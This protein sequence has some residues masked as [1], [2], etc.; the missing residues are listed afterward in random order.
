MAATPP[1]RSPPSPTSVMEVNATSLLV[2]FSPE[3]KEKALPKKRRPSLAKAALQLSTRELQHQTS[4]FSSTYWHILVGVAAFFDFCATVLAPYFPEDDGL[5][6]VTTK[7]LFFNRHHKEYVVTDDPLLHDVLQWLDTWYVQIGVVFSV[8]LFVDAI[9]KAA[10]K[11]DEKIDRLRLLEDERDPATGSAWRA[12]Y[13]TMAFQLLVLPV[14]FYVALWGTLRFRWSTSESS[15]VDDESEV[16]G[17]F[18]IRSTHSLLFA[19]LNYTFMVTNRLVGAGIRSQRKALS[20]R[21]ARRMARF[22]FRHPRLFRYRLRLSLQIIRWIKYLAPLVGGLNKLFGNTM[23]LLKKYRQRVMANRA[24][25]MRKQRWHE[26]SPLQKR[27]AAA[28]LIQKSFRG[29]ES[30]KA[31]RALN[32]LEGCKKTMIAIKMQQAF[33]ASLARARER[34]A[35]KKRELKRL[36]AQAA[37]AKKHEMSDD[38]RRLMYQLQDELGMRAKELVNK[39]LLLRPNTTFAVTWKFLFVMCVLYEISMNCL[40]HKLQKYKDEETGKPLDFGRILEHKFVPSPISEWE[41]CAPWFAGVAEE[42][43][44]VQSIFGQKQTIVEGCPWY[45]QE[46]VVT[47][48]SVYI[49]VLRFVLSRALVLIGVVMF[50]DVFVTFFTGELHRE[51]G[52]LIP[53]PF[54]KRWLLPGLVLQLLVNPQMET[55]SRWVGRLLNGIFHVGPVRAWRWTAALWYP[56]LNIISRALEVYIWRPLV[57]QQNQDLEERKRKKAAAQD[58]VEPE[59]FRR[60]SVVRLSMH[61]QDTAFLLSIEKMS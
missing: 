55:T 15:E 54:V 29:M 52:M 14:G 40:K 28:I 58:S 4:S 18:V 48:Q 3:A 37:D 41:G 34:I 53:K 10:W 19:C 12:F 13:C 60:R 56:L 26:L 23:D 46:P 38:D 2:S 25:R 1:K 57:K 47:A 36:Q 51:N 11:R 22:A 17:D 35:E 5:Q 24:I 8:L 7:G 49:I 44:F 16:E 30:R 43:S 21:V 39:K 50:F 61:E 32:M 42:Q 27:M 45:C 9:V 33:R 31:V 59:D 20:R 6:T